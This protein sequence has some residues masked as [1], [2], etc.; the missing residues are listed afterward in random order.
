LTEKL[1]IHP[2]PQITHHPFNALLP[3]KASK[4]ANFHLKTTAF[5]SFLGVSK[6]YP[7]AEK[8]NHLVFT[9]V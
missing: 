9:K 4:T 3:Q 8:T 7:L 1:H 2:K 5:W 6:I